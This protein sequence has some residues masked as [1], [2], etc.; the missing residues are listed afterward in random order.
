MRI[1]GI[2][3]SI[4]GFEWIGLIYMKYVALNLNS[5]PSSVEYRLC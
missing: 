2:W 5:K 4:D 3:E 1:K